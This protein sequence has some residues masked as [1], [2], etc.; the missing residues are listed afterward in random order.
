MDEEVWGAMVTWSAVMW[1]FW[2]I[3]FVA[4]V[5]LVPITSTV[6]MIVTLNMI[7]SFWAMC[8]VWWKYAGIVYENRRKGITNEDENVRTDL[9]N[10]E[11]HEFIKK[12]RPYLKLLD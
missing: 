2:T 1:I 3:V 11:I 7:L 6:D 5:N 8:A 4:V 10:R 9:F 12:H